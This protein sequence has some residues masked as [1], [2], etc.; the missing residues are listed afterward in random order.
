[1]GRFLYYCLP[2]R[3][4]VIKANINQVFQDKLSP[5][6]KKKLMLAFYSH[7]AKSIKEFITMRF[8]SESQITSKVEVRGYEHFL[9]LA[10]KNQGVL[11]LTGH[12]GNW[13]FAPIAGILNFKQFKGKFHFIRKTIG[14]KK[15][16]KILFR[17]YY[18]S[19]LEVIP[20]KNSLNHVCD[21]LNQNDAVVFVM[22]QHANVYNR[23]GIAVEFFGKKAGTYRSL[24]TLSRYTN[25]P[26][27]PS[28]SYRLANGKHVLEFFPPIPWKEYDNAKD[29]LYYNTLAYNKALEALV[30]KH[31]EQWL[32]MHK[33]WK[34]S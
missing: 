18:K 29:A 1:M 15:L 24:A 2:Y 26:V 16:E 9:K 33:R 3:K 34:L 22:D 27:M 17:R 31:P 14:N 25:L 13:E 20:T 7:M 30:L 19:G 10:E 11:I 28:S 21:V 23:D 4:R 32:W 12:F 8:M 5:K 6:Q